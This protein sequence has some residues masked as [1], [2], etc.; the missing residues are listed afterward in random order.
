M[1]RHFLEQ[2]MEACDAGKADLAWQPGPNWR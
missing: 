2:R 1:E